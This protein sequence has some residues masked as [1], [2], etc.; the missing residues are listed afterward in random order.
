MPASTE[1]RDLKPPNLLLTKNLPVISSNNKKGISKEIFLSAAE[2]HVHFP[3][4][5][6]G[7]KPIRGAGAHLLSVCVRLEC[8]VPVVVV[9]KLTAYHLGAVLILEQSLHLLGRQIQ[10]PCTVNTKVYAPVH[11]PAAGMVFYSLYQHPQ[12]LVQPPGLPR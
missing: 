5:G 6:G 3:R 9:S 1:A 11:A 2:A 12:I 8:N 4:A 10:G 7:L